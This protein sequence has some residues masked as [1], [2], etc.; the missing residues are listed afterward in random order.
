MSNDNWQCSLSP[1][2]NYIIVQ[3]NTGWGLLTDM[4]LFRIPP[5]TENAP[6]FE[7][8][9]YNHALTSVFSKQT[10]AAFNAA[11]SFLQEMRNNPKPWD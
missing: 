2:K 8:T 6:I 9:T 10:E 11:A 7:Y 1:A 3:N 4:W 5:D